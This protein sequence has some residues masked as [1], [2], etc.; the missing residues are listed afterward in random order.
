MDDDEPVWEPGPGTDAAGQRLRRGGDR[1]Q[2]VCEAMGPALRPEEV[3]AAEA[4]GR[5]AAEQQPSLL[6]Q[7][8]HQHRWQ[9]L[10]QTIKL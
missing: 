10:Q 7:G 2:F 1:N 6:P 3:A 5:P 8:L 4:A 9:T